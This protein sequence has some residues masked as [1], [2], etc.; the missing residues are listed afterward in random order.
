L[1]GTKAPPT[2]DPKK[3]SDK[4][5]KPDVGHWVLEQ[6]A[7]SGFAGAK[8]MIKLADLTGDK[9]MA[10]KN[11]K[12]CWDWDRVSNDYLDRKKLF[13]ELLMLAIFLTGGQPPRGPEIGTIKFRNTVGSLRNFFVGRF[14]NGFYHISYNKCHAISNHGF[15]VARFLPRE[16]TRLVLLAQPR[17]NEFVGRALWLSQCVPSKVFQQRA[18]PY[19]TNCVTGP[20]NFSLRPRITTSDLVRG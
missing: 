16:V 9:C 7:K 11:G 10:E 14:G 1:F 5:A 3:L 15:H 19:T 6:Y 20:L 18:S 2:I 17:R 13:L 12:D 4:M 8:F